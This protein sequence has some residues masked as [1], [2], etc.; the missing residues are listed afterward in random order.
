MKENDYKN[1]VL[2]LRSLGWSYNK[3]ANE[4]GC[5]KSTVS[6]Y[7]SDTTKEKVKHRSKRW[8][9]EN[10][11]Q[12]TLCHKLSN[13]R[14]RKNKDA[15]R[16]MCQD[17]NKKLRTAVS[18]FRRSLSMK[19]NNNYTYKDVIE[20]FGGTIVT[21]EL[22]GQTIDLTK[23]DYQIDHII[24]VSRGG[25]NELENMAFVIPQVNLAKSNLTNDEFVELCKQVCEHFGYTVTK[26]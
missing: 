19:P 7:L 6:Y 5:S 24:P 15:K 1:K 23:D 10:T 9:S 12:D 17:W 16:T 21:C 13:F 8:K 11:W 20:Y 4:L 22:T 3:I 25:T 26:Q 14:L 18:T 2:E